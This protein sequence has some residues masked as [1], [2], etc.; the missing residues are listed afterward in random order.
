[1]SKTFRNKIEKI[2]TKH[3]FEIFTFRENFEN[4]WIEFEMR[5]ANKTYPKES[6][7][8]PLAAMKKIASATGTNDVQSTIYDISRAKDGTDDVAYVLVTGVD[9]KKAERVR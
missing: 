7:Y 6:F 4:G 8:M 9:M 3:G 1:M 5:N 2:A